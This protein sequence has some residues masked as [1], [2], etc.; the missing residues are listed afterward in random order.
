MNHDVTDPVCGMT[1]PEADAADSVEHEGMKYYFC[2]ARCATRFHTDPA[3][4]VTASAVDAAADSDAVV[5][6]TCPMHPAI[7]QARPGACPL[8]GMALEPAMPGA[9][10]TPSEEERDMTRRLV[11]ATMCSMPLVAASM[12]SMLRSEERRV[13]KEC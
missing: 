5:E 9:D 6:Y 2:A 13:G 3:R 1:F 8:C 11:V 4:Y 12:I 7:R 10:D